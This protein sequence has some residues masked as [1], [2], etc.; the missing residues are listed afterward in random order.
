VSGEERV[1][2]AAGRLVTPSAVLAPGW[3]E[4]AGS[5]LAA[6]EAGT[7]PRPADVDLTGQ[8]LVPGFVDVHVHGG[9]GA[10]YAS[11]DPDEAVR[12]AALHAQH[13]TTTTM[14]SL[15]TAEMSA[16]ERQLEVLRDLVED[17]LL[18]GIHLEGRG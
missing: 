2:I 17:G 4:V 6:V 14:A 3:L 18:A 9:G 5:R 7:P 13:G 12:V 8:T 15:V 1:L 10:S 16:L 11:G